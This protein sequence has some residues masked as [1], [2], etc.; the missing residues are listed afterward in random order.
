MARFAFAVV[1]F[2]ELCCC[3]L[4]CAAF[5]GLESMVV[6]LFNSGESMV[7][8]AESMVVCLGEES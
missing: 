8:S 7:H 2:I 5:S 4:H 6:C 3:S 1:K